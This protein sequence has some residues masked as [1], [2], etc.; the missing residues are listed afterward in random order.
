MRYWMFLAYAVGIPNF[1][2]FDSTGKTHSQGLFNVTSIASITLTLITAFV[3][4]A[5]TILNR[6]EVQLPKVKFSVG[7][8]IPLLALFIVASILQPYSR[9]V[10]FKA[11]DLP[12]SIYRLGEW[13]LAFLMLVSLYRRERNESKPDLIIRLISSVCWINI[14][15]VWLA[16]PLVPS[17]VYASP[18]DTAQGYPRLGGMMIHPVHLAILAGVAFL[19][20]MLFTRGLI[21][22]AACSLAFVTLV[23]TYAR[24]ELLVFLAILAIYSLL[25]TRSVVLRY[26][27]ILCW[28]G[29]GSL[30]IVFQEQ[31]LTYLARGRGVRNIT[32]LSE[33]TLVWQASFKAIANRP[34][35]GYGYIAGAKNALHDQWTAS[36]W[37]PPHSH[38]EF[39]QA[40]M[41]GG[42][43][44]GVLMALIYGRVL[45]AAIASAS[46][47]IKHMFLLMAIVQITVMAFIMPLLTVQFERESALFVLVFVGVVGGQARRAKKKAEELQEVFA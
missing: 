6:N 17:L 42:I 38:S 19:H 35:I 36:N 37:I 2:K 25:L 45:W 39:I 32:T 18:N 40:T 14:A 23:M 12:L 22:V 47:G 43:V 44:A 13:T 41:S 28:L 11:T 46:G 4:V 24:S 34:Y 20:A 33:R 16:L 8:W 10:A 31:I 9:T 29:L 21:R 3:F 30:A 1:L 27:G 7:L 26:S 5:L 15:F